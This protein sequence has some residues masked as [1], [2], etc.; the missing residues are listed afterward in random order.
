MALGAERQVE[1]VLTPIQ[2]IHVVDAGAT[3]GLGITLALQSR[4]ASNPSELNLAR[5]KFQRAGV[6]RIWLELVG[7]LSHI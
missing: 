3:V 2:C 7:V 6:A 4:T 5:H 1:C